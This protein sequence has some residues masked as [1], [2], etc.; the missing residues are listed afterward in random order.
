MSFKKG[1]Q[2]GGRKSGS[3]GKTNLAVKTAFADLL[4]NNLQ[5]L[6]SDIDKLQP[7]DRLKIILDLAGF[8]IPKQKAIEQSVEVKQ[9]VIPTINFVGIE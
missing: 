5:K 9:A 1:N 7:K 8:V 2:L 6:Q 3:L 4:N